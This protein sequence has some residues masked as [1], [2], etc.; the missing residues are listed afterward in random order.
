[1]YELCIVGLGAAGLAAAVTASQLN[2]KTICIEKNKKAGRKLYATGNGKCNLAN[3]YMDT[4]VVY[5]SSCE[6]YKEYLGENDKLTD[7]LLDFL[8]EIG[9]YSYANEKGYVYPAS[10]QASAVVW[11]MLDAINRDVVDISYGE[12]VIDIVYRDGYYSIKC[13][14]REYRAKKVLLACGGMSYKSLGGGCEGYELAEK[15]GHT[16]TELRPSLCA[17]TTKDLITELAGVRCAARAVL[18][19][20]AGNKLASSSGELQLTAQGLSG[21]MIFNLISRYYKAV[22]YTEPYVELS[23][24]DGLDTNKILSLY[25]ISSDRTLVALLNAFLNDKLAY[26]ICKGHGYDKATRVKDIPRESFVKL[27]DDISCYRVNIDGTADFENAQ[28][29]SGG[30]AL[31]EL[32]SHSYES[33]IHSNIYIV[34]EML[35]I[36]GICGGYN[37]TFAMI[38]GRRAVLDI[39]DKN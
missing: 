27:I 18:M 30:V 11:T 15:L 26:F 21:I 35:D 9:I 25:D 4:G 39:Y 38:S 22:D 23:F 8:E 7:E 20:A 13:P 24:T 5:N 37:I 29:T 33:K 28:V 19:D 16:I 1:M 36:D 17:F 31:S 12:P 14:K 10:N 3:T 2:I 32:C 6:E 34:G